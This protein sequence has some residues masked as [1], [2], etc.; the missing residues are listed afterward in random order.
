M[1]E[2]T[3][4]SECLPSTGKKISPHKP[5]QYV[6]PLKNKKKIKYRATTGQIAQK[7]D[8]GKEKAHV[9]FI[10]YTKE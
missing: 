5:P 4:K 2:E 7:S 9:F 6:N 1:R 8:D 3:E 10:A